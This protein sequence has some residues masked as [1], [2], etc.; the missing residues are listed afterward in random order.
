MIM[1]RAAF[2]PLAAAVALLPVAAHAS[3]FAEIVNNSIVPL[4]NS[5]VNLIMALCFIFF[6]I[7][8]VRYFMSHNAESRQQGKYFAIYG[9]AA[10]ALLFAVWGIVRF[11]VSIISSFNT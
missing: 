4:G 1:R 2:I 9:I 5:V 11:L 6:L 3:T 10:F 8:M 7:G